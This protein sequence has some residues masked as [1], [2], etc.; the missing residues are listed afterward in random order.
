MIAIMADRACVT[1]GG[2]G[3]GFSF[4]LPVRENATRA[5]NTIGSCGR[6]GR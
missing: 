2:G 3:V 6:W 5:V 4:G 1:E